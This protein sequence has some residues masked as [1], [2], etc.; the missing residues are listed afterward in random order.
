VGRRHQ[1]GIEISSSEAPH[2]RAAV[3]SS[4]HGSVGLGVR[5]GP[6]LAGLAVVDR[7]G[8]SQRE[9]LE[10]LGLAGDEFAE[11]VFARSGV[12]HRQLNLEPEFLDRNLQGRANKVEQQLLVE[13]VHAVEQLDIDPSMIGTVLT[14]SL[15]SLGCPTLA[16]RLVEH[17]RM[18]P[19]IDKYHVTG[20]GCASAVPLLRLG[21]Q[22]LYANPSRQVLVVAAES[23][24]SIMM[25]ARPGDP[26]AKTVGSA[27]FGDGCAAALLSSDRTGG[28]PSIV[29]TAVHQIPDSL[30]AVELAGEDFDSHLHLARDLPEIAAAELPGVVHSFLASQHVDE[31]QIRHWML[32]PGGRRIVEQ[33]RDALG[34]DDEDVALTWQALAEHGNVGT[35]SIFY[36]L[37]NTIQT[38]RPA[39]GEYGLAVTIGPGVSVGLML[40]RF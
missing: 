5:P 39:P 35:P 24:S 25:R 15:Y 40:L 9:V 16:H 34:L 26:R 19:A 1:A 2:R 36:V 10:R 11:G 23:M 32:H 20:V 18:P 29:A 37:H 12:Q 6:R 28:G 4:E 22:T 31:E 3:Q 21:V 30:G 17:Y 27:I 13:A 14:S 8:S 7:A 38:S 33:A